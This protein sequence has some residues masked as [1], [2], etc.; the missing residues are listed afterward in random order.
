MKLQYLAYG[1][2]NQILQYVFARYVERRSPQQPVIFDDTFFYIRDPVPHNG[3]ELESVFGLHLH[4]L[5][6]YLDYDTWDILLSLKKK[7]IFLP[8]VLLDAGMPIAVASQ[9]IDLSFFRGITI[10]RNEITSEIWK[11][12]FHNIYYYDWWFD[13]YWFEAD[14]KEN[15]AELT[16]PTLKDNRNLEYAE[17]IQN[18]FSVGIHVRRSDFVKYGWAVPEGEYLRACKSVLAQN[19]DAW[20]FIFSDEV[21]WCRSNAMHLGFNLSAHTIYVEGNVLGKN[22]IDMQLLSM[23]YGIIRPGLSTF[24]K[25]AA[26]LN[27]NLSFDIELGENILEYNKIPKITA[28]KK[29]SSYFLRS[30]GLT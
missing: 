29:G 9:A 7:G 5:S 6:H 22:Y 28:D 11:L 4:Q 17:K 3:F 15:L 19:P 23:C 1:L 16:F 13:S 14:K 25:V 12:P 20:F 18:N 24:S 21:D 26:Y 30:L 8:Q 27:R 10:T 2:G